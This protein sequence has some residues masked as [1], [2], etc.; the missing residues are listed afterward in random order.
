M[1]SDENQPRPGGRD[2]IVWFTVRYRT[3]ALAAVAA[4]ALAVLGWV[5]FAPR[6]PPQPPPATRI[7][8]GARF[9]IIEGSVQVK[10]AGRLEWLD[11]TKA[12]V[13]R[14]NDLVR[15]GPGGAAEI[16]FEDGS[17]FSVRP[18]SLIT[19]A[20]SSQN[21]LSREQRVALSIESGEANFQTPA[22]GVPG[23]TTIS[24]PTVRTTAERDTAG[25]IQVEQT[26]ATGLRIF[27]GTGQVQTRTGQRVSLGSNEGVRVDSAGAAGA[28]VALPVVPQLNAPPDRSELLFPDLNQGLTMLTWTAVPGAEAYRV[29][30]DFSPSFARPLYDRRG[31]RGTQMELRALEAGSYFWK[32]SA[33]DAGG[34]EGGFSELWRFSIGRTAAAAATPPPLAVETLEIKG[35]V[36]HVRGRTEPGS[37][38]TVNGE[39][40]DVQADGSFDEFLTFEGGATAILVRATSARGGVAE[41]RRRA[42][43]VN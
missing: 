23:S 24:T 39:R 43:V 17:I 31:Q 37:A 13:L 2:R 42:V 38:L 29:V 28:K 3:L 40:L 5:L 15:T 4:I 12:M 41:M 33:L 7:E 20:E 35:N 26:G 27:K 10:R 19:L 25:N 30:V 18:D 6:T 11:A 1:A 32:V 16:R 9:T 21:P 34:A 14:Q 22:R 36:L 8:T